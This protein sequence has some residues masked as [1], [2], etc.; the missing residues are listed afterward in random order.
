MTNQPLSEHLELE[1]MTTAEA[2]A[3]LERAS[4]ALIPV[5]S[6]EQHGRNMTLATDTRL[7]HAVSL[8]LAERMR[9][10]LIVL[11]PIPVG[12]SYHHME[13]PGS[14]T[15]KPSTL[16]AVVRDYIESLK[17]Y[18]I[19]SF[20]FMNGHG[21]NQA[22]L[23]VMTTLARYELGVRAANVFYWNLAKSE[24]AERVESERYGHACEMEASFGL[25]LAPDTVREDQ[26]TPAKL[27]EYPMRF[28]AFERAERVEVP[29][30]WTEL[31]EDGT[32]GD[33]RNA[34]YELG[35]EITELILVRLEAFVQDFM[36]TAHAS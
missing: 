17:G 1:L 8:R 29:F 10:H 18:G 12:I 4:V 35:A 36:E 26:L 24:I 15:L 33:A 25:Y 16:Q 21:G 2:E 31:T 34:S 14:L 30:S 13:F 19:R 23:S 32:F 5:G 7:A 22:A 11:P 3:A 28:T 20:V 27:R 6:T 9:P